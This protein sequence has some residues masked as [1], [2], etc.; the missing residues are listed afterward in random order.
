MQRPGLTRILQR[1]NRL[2]HQH[3]RYSRTISTEPIRVAICGAGPAGF[4]SASRLFALDQQA[5]LDRKISIDLFERLPSPF[6]LSRYGVAPD[7]PEVKVC[8]S[9][10]LYLDEKRTEKDI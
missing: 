7:H 8:L 4:Y 1:A 2:R 3:R 9:L 5:V 6:G 10:S